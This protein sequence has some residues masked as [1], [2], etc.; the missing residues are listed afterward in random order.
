M[1]TGSVTGSTG[2]VSRVYH[3]L[4]LSK[5]ITTGIFGMVMGMADG[6]PIMIFSA[7]GIVTKVAIIWLFY[8]CRVSPVAAERRERWLAA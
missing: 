6:W 1:I 5:D 2:G 3:A 4:I 7:V 8:W